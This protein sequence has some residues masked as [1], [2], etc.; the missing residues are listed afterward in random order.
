MRQAIERAIRAAG[1]QSKLAAAIGV[2]PPAIA[3][4]RHGARPVPPARCVQIER[5]TGG[6]VMRWDLRDDW[7]EIWP[8][9]VGRIGAPE[10]GPPSGRPAI[11]V[12]G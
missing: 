12:A 3:E 5:I 9:L 11:D 10:A 6:A 7:A 1:G 8:E 2:T 4:W